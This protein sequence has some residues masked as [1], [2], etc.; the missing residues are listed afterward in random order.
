M[1]RLIRR[2]IYALPAAGVLTAVPWLYILRGPSLRTDPDGFARDAVSPASAIAGDVYLAGFICLLF[3]LLALYAHLVRTPAASWAAGGMV[4]SV[5]GVASALPVFGVF[6]LASAILGDVYLAGHKDVVAA[7]LLMGGGTPSD[8]LNS[9]F[10]ALMLIALI[11]SIA[12][13]VAVWRSRT[14]PKWAGVLLVPGSVLSMTFGPLAWAGALCLII[15]GI[16]LARGVDQAAD[17]TVM[18]TR[19]A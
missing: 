4:V 9:Y 7:M 2:G 19:T 5:V 17:P 14:L 10:G 12:N 1:T 8:R 3:G 13:A 18:A 6:G 16:G 11:G 15:A